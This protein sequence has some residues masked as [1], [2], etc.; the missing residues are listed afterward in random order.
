[1]EKRP[2]QLRSDDI[3][4]IERTSLRSLWLAARDFSVDAWEYFRQSQDDPKDIAE[5]ITREMLDRFSGFQIQQR[6]FGN[7]DY[8]K[9]RYVIHPG[10]AVRQALFVDSK[11]EKSRNSATLQ[12]SQTSLA[13]RQ[14][15]GGAPTDI[16]GAIPQITTYAG[17]EYLT[18]TLLAHYH[19]AAASGNDSKD[20]PPYRLLALTLVAVPN[21]LLQ[22]RY[23]PD[24]SD[25]IWIAGRNAPSL[26]ESFRVRLSFNRLAQKARWRVQTFVFDED[27]KTTDEWSEA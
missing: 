9:A 19:Y 5:D 3:E 11:A 24:Q 26:G 13:V 22:E 12:M 6:I 23:N 4:D 17:F 21:G 14:H 15:R 27:G 10:L 20:R 16:Q 18:T 2:G 7:V 8:R 25:T 1:M